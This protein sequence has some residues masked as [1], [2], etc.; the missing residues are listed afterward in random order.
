MQG[1]IK[2]LRVCISL[3]L[4]TQLDPFQRLGLCVVLHRR[5]CF[6]RTVKVRQQDY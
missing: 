6:R 5:C 3:R 4:S 1:A 2:Q